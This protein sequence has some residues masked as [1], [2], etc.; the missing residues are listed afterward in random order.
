M[1][2]VVNKR[3][4]KVQTLF[5]ATQHYLYELVNPSNT[6]QLNQDVESP[7]RVVENYK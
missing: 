3:T 7:Y 1:T 6:A 2:F 4:F 5:S